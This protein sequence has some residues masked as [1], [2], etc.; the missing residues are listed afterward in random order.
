MGGRP[1]TLTPLGALFTSKEDP[2]DLRDFPCI[3]QSITGRLLKTAEEILDLVRKGFSNSNGK[4]SHLFT[5]G[6]WVFD[7]IQRFF[8]PL[9]PYL[10]SFGR[11]RE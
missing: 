3:S 7:F 9:S 10:P 6:N 4:I 11:M 2:E 5:E 1:L 8:H